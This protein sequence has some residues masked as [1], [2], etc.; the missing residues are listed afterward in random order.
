MLLVCGYD[1][2]SCCHFVAYK[3]RCD[4]GLDAKFAA[5][6]VLTNRYVLHLLR[7][8]ALACK[9]HLCIALLA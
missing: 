6:H 2:T 9:R 8:H 4:T 3:L 5:V 1:G 7:Y